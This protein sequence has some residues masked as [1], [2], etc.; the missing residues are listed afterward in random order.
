MDVRQTEGL[1]SGGSGYVVSRDTG[2]EELADEVAVAIG[3]RFGKKPYLVVAGSHRKFVDLNRP[4]EMAYADPDAKPIYDAYHTALRESCSE[5]QKKHHKGL[6]LDIH[7]Q[8]SSAN[9]VYRGTHDGKT[10]TL[11]RER[12]GD[13]A[14]ATDQS[15]FGGLKTRGWKV[16]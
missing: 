9:T 4:A 15:L 7:G 2:T 14:H 13:E 8:N 1:K 5:V 3:Y 6:L 12:F 10:V 11:L 16:H